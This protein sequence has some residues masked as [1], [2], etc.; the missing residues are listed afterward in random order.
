MKPVIGL[1]HVKISDVHINF[2]GGNV[3]VTQQRLHRTRIR[4]V[5]H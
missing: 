1:A 5:L 4:A 2:G 3:R